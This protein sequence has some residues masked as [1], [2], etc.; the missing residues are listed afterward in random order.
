MLLYFLNSL[1]IN[2]KEEDVSFVLFTK[3]STIFLKIEVINVYT[4]LFLFSSLFL[5]TINAN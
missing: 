4:I 3:I 1:F 5:P 2:S